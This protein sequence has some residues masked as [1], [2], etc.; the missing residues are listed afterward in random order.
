[1]ISKLT[2]N[3]A[4]TLSLLLLCVQADRVAG[5]VSFPQPATAKSDGWERCV[6]EDES[7]DSTK[8]Q[9]A[10]QYMEDA[11]D[12]PNTA[13]PDEDRLQFACVIR[14]GRMIWPNQS[15]PVHQGSDLNT[16]CQIYSVTKTTPRRG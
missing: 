8:L 6:P 9:A 4:V 11:L 2:P 5:Q 13:N 7:V 12:D 10:M 3:S 15:T 1:M 16:P 14:N